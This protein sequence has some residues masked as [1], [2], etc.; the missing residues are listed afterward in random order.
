MDSGMIGGIV[1]SAIGVLGGIIGTYFSIKNTKG[2][3]ERAFMVKASIV[4]WGALILFFA[5]M[6]LLPHPYRHFLWIPYGVLLP[7]GIIKGN[8]IQ[9]ELRKMESEN[10]AQETG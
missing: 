10:G 8:R 6:I 4:G 3:S 7:L 5:L 1:G 2:P 9:A